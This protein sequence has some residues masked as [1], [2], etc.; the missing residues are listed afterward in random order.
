MAWSNPVNRDRANRL[1]PVFALGALA[2]W[3]AASLSNTLTF[4]EVPG[5]RTVTIGLLACAALF[6]FVV[7]PVVLVTS[8]IRRRIKRAASALGGMLVLLGCFYVSP[9]GPGAFRMDYWRLQYRRSHYM[10]QVEQS[11]SAQPR[12]AAFPWGTTGGA[13]LPG[14]LVYWLVYD[15]SGEIANASASRSQAWRERAAGL[16]FVANPGGCREREVQLV[17]GHFHLLI[18]AC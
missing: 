3:L 2:I 7:L 12:L 17:E 8:L 5:F 11:G 4:W 15:E 9:L 1:T 6:G 14:T 13:G 10:E 16:P 18:L